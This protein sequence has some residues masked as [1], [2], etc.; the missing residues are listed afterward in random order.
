MVKH[1]NCNIKSLL[2]FP[3][4]VTMKVSQ[5]AFS[6]CGGSA[7]KHPCTVSPRCEPR[8]DVRF[9][10]H[11]T[12]LDGFVHMLYLAILSTRHIHKLVIKNWDCE[13]SYAALTERST[14]P[15]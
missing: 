6:C 12:V 3:T 5:S 11:I 1:V 2:Y 9:K 13:V 10:I 15:N 7:D 4:P 8:D 14:L